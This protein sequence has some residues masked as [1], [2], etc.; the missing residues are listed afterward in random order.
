MEIYLQQNF[1][2]ELLEAKS[3]A[4][5]DEEHYKQRLRMDVRQQ[6]RMFATFIEKYA[7]KLTAVKI[8]EWDL[9]NYVVVSPVSQAGQQLQES[10]VILYKSQLN[11]LRVLIEECYYKIKMWC[12]FIGCC[13]PIP[14]Y[15]LPD[16]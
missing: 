12:D 10:Q 8:G 14:S 4:D 1:N 15:I 5:Y 3:K 16:Y 2:K 13:N 6:Q 9:L 7:E 11:H